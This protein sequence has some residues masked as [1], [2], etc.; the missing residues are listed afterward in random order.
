MKLMN[1]FATGMTIAPVEKK[2][3]LDTARTV[4]RATSRL[5]ALVPWLP[6]CTA[7]FNVCWCELAES[8]ADPVLS[9]IPK[10]TFSFF[11]EANTPTCT[12]CHRDTF[13]C[14]HQA[15]NQERVRKPACPCVCRALVLRIDQGWS[16]LVF[17]VL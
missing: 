5:G 15:R 14:K 13:F 2:E 12:K 17:K 8:Q 7:E 10:H 3:N 1:K 4:R 6:T 9:R 16:L 11:R